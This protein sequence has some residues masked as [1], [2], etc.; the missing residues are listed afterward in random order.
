MVNIGIGG[1]II[2]VEERANQGFDLYS[3]IEADH[4]ITNAY[5]A[6]YRPIATLQ[7]DGPFQFK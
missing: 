1:N 4:S 6:E 5:D 3:S 2:N 7:D